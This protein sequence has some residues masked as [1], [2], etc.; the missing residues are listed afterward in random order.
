M[1]LA[2]HYIVVT[3]TARALD[4]SYFISTAEMGSPL[5]AGV[6]CM[7]LHG[8]EK[9]SEIRLSV[10]VERN[11]ATWRSTL[12]LFF[13][14]RRIPCGRHPAT[15]YILFLRS[16]TLTRHR[17]LVAS[18]GACTDKMVQLEKE[19]RTVEHRP[20]IKAGDRVM[21]LKTHVAICGWPHKPG[22]FFVA[23][24]GRRRSPSSAPICAH[25]RVLALTR[26]HLG[27]FGSR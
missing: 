7:Y 21:L 4:L 12:W 6:Y 23:S 3:F 5:L 17:C 8:S 27:A 16:R 22:P 9:D 15:V 18:A 11:L 20:W 14:R 24:T 2:L 25:L 1:F 26:V 10:E 19:Q 13:D